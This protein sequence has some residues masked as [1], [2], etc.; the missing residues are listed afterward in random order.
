[1]AGSQ[2]CGYHRM[3]VAEHIATSAVGSDGMHECY[4]SGAGTAFRV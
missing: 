2:D 4:S 3:H 1:V